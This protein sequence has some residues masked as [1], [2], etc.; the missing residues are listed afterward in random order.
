M[1]YYLFSIGLFI[2]G[3][4]SMAGFLFYGPYAVELGEKIIMTKE[5]FAVSCHN[6]C[7]SNIVRGNISR[8]EVQQYVFRCEGGTTQ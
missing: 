5:D 1:K 7:L 2:A 4:L 8:E 3:A 6:V